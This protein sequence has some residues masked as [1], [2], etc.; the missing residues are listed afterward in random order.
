MGLW[1]RGQ[2]PRQWRAEF[3]DVSTPELRRKVGSANY[4]P[5]KQQFLEGLLWRREH[6]YTVVIIIGIIATVITIIATVITIIKPF[7]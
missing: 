7:W 1:G 6:P 3:K 5:A 4:P 2:Q